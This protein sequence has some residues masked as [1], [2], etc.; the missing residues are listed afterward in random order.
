MTKAVRVAPEEAEAGMR[1]FIDE[2][3]RRLA[4]DEDTCS[5]VEDVLIDPSGDRKSL[6][7]L[8]GWRV[9]FPGRTRPP[10]ELRSL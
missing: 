5:V 6:R 3:D 9:G 10:A 8:A 1:E 2:V 7:A 4:S